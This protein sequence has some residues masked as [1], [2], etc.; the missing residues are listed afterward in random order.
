MKDSA[1]ILL[2]SRMR[3]ACPGASWLGN[4][5]M[6]MFTCICVLQLD[7]QW[8][9]VLSEGWA[10]PLKGFMREK[11]YLQAIH[12]DT[13]LDGMCFSYLLFTLH[14]LKKKKIVLRNFH[15]N[16]KHSFLVLILTSSL[17]LE[18]FRGFVICLILLCINLLS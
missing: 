1:F 18:I 5:A 11:E 9:Q 6:E 16:R 17:L 15:R 8:V 4:R 7:L 2:P 12:F 10:T 3:K 13:L 14:C